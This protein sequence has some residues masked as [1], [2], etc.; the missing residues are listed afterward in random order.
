[1]TE[2]HKK[3]V[4]ELSERDSLTVPL[5]EAME[6]VLKWYYM[7][8]SEMEPEVLEYVYYNSFGGKP[9]IEIQ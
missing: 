6:I 4:M 8:Y 9:R 1:M 3:M 5:S 2:E 7:R